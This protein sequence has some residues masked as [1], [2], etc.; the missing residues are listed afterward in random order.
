MSTQY[1]AIKVYTYL[2]ENTA[3]MEVL[4]GNSAFA[5]CSQ[6][7]LKCMQIG[8]ARPYL[9]TSVKNGIYSSS[10]KLRVEKNYFKMLFY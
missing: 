9:R 3:D 1:S 7:A 10:S 8:H 6:N 4:V 5:V 2:H